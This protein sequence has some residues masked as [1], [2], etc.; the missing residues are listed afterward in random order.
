MFEVA[1]DRCA[2]CARCARSLDG[3]AETARVRR[4]VVDVA[5]LLPRVT[6]YRLVSRRCGGCG[7]VS[8]PAAGD[9]PRPVSPGGDVAPPAAGAPHEAGARDRAHP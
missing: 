9:V 2:R 5:P 7:H 6:E 8:E 3:A 1:P 4:Q